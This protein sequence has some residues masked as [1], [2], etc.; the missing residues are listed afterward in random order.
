MLDPLSIH[1]RILSGDQTAEEELIAF[2][3]NKYAREYLRSL[4][5]LGE[6]YL[7]DLCMTVIEGIRKNSVEHPQFLITY[8]QWK[9]HSIRLHA[10]RKASQASKKLIPITEA[11]H[12]EDPHPGADVT[13]VEAERARIVLGLIHT[14]DSVSREIVLRSYFEKQKA[15]E[16][17]RDM[18]LTPNEYRGRKQRAV[19][20]LKA[21][22]RQR[23]G[24]REELLAA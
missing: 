18:N 4:G 6:D 2:L 8:C 16:I 17:Q 14:L 9:A 24:E 13:L 10:I 22:Y 19:E 23:F 12:F 1:S 11:R 20:R 21:E 3:R 5:P 7:Q 15:E